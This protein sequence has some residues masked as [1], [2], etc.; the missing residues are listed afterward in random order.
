LKQQQRTTYIS[1]Q[2]KE[3]AKKMLSLMGIPVVQAP[4]EAEAQCSY[5]N[6][7]GKVDAVCTEDTDSIVFG[8][9]LLLREL[10]NKK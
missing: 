4:G 6:K 2:E 10:S 7:I 9:Q 3:D 1:H 8:T 5:L